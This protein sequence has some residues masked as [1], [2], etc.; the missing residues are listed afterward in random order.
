[1]EMLTVVGSGAK[2]SSKSKP[3]VAGKGDSWWKIF[4][5]GA[6][7]LGNVIYE[8]GPAIAKFATE[9]APSIMKAVGFGARG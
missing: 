7:K 9:N 8:N 1:M 2:K 4:K 3:Q 6:S 5:E